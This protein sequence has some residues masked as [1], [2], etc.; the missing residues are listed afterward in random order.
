MGG[1]DFFFDD[2]PKSSVK[3]PIAAE[4]EP[5]KKEEEPKKKPEPKKKLDDSGTQGI[6]ITNFKRIIFR[7]WRRF[8]VTR[9]A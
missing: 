5:K 2:K 8:W 7:L 1:K 9:Y 3:A 4:P 6:V